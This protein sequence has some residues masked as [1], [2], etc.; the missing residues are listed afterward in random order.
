MAEAKTYGHQTGLDKK[1]PS[2]SGA[3]GFW[4]IG[5]SIILFYCPDQVM[6]KEIRG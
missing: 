6:N 3:T 5:V 2:H 1:S 4:H